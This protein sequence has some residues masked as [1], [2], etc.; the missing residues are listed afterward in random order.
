MNYFSWRNSNYE[1]KGSTENLQFKL[2]LSSWFV[3]ILDL[4]ACS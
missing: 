3:A 4:I 2:T 1:I